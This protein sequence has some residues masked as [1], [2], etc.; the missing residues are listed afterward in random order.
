[1]SKVPSTRSD[2]G[3]SR[4]HEH[5]DKISTTTTL[6]VL[7]AIVLL[8]YAIRLVLLPFVLSG[9]LA[10]ICTPLIEWLTARARMPRALVAISI[11][12]ILVLIGAS[13]AYAGVPPLIVE[14]KRFLTDLDP[15][16]SRMVR[17]A[18]GSEPVKLFGQQMDA[19]QIAQAT[20]AGF[21]N[22]IENV[23]V[24]TFMGGAAIGS[25]FG[26]FLTL[27]LL[28]YFLVSGPRIAEGLFWLVPPRQRPLI[29]GDIWPKLDPVLRRYFVGVIAVVIFAAAAAYIG[30]GIF[31][32][33]PHASFLALLTGLL[34]AIPV[35]GP[36]T[37]AVIA[38]I[39]ALQ[40]AT[41]FG[42]IIG[43]AIYL[44]VLRLS[45]DQLFGPL[46]LGTAARVHPVLIIFCFLSG[47]IL[48]GIVGVIMAVPV[49]LIAKI[50][51]ATL[52]D[53]PQGPKDVAKRKPA[54]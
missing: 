28:F 6:F 33:L 9:L 12:L 4:D 31:L 48:F 15:M 32:K 17:G 52:Y 47:G 23:N 8:L 30:L 50:T 49:A 25:A 27:I 22:W 24:L 19:T 26:S 11:F 14:V 29:Q 18:I 41:G 10:Y 36:T 46:V 54:R 39:V 2:Q 7:A 37:A 44:A 16:I 20:A 38:G 40:H 45:I 34:E 42:L 43:Y 5:V 3:I 21:R 1:M 13:I 35:V 51:L 53:E